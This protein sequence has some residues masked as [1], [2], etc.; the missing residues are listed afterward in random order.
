MYEFTKRLKGLQDDLGYANDVRVA[1]DILPELDAGARHGPVARAGRRLLE[2]HKQALA[3]AEP[4][5]GRRID[6]LRD[7]VPFWRE[8]AAPNA[9]RNRVGS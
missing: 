1:R 9:R 7:A 4:K 8:H 6:R 2:W 5:L 3:K